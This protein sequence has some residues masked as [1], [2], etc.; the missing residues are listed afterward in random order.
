M[1]GVLPVSNLAQKDRH[2]LGL[3]LCAGC[4]HGKNPQVYGSSTGR[5]TE[6]LF[7]DDGDYFSEEESVASR[8][9]HRQLSHQFNRPS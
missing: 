8:T 4:T 3:R 2:F 1:Q 5:H 7:L 6:Q 9:L